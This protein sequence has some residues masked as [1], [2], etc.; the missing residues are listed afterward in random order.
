MTSTWNDFNS[1]DDQ[2]SFDLIPKGTL[3]FL[4]ALPYNSI[5]LHIPLNRII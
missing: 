2:N 4:I 3:V 1:A 5:N